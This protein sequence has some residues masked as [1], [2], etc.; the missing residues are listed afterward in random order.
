MKENLKPCV[1][2]QREREE[3]RDLVL[4]VERTGELRYVAR[5]SAEGAEPKRKR[6]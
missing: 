3:R 4:F 5:L 6:V 1:Y 2:K